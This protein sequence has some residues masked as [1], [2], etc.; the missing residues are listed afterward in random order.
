MASPAR[1]RRPHAAADRDLDHRAQGS[2]VNGGAGDGRRARWLGLCA[3]QRQRRDTNGSTPDRRAGRRPAEVRPPPASWQFTTDL[4]SVANGA[5]RTLARGFRRRLAGGDRRAGDRLADRR[6]EG[7]RSDQHKHVSSRSTISQGDQ[8]WTQQHDGVTPNQANGVAFAADGS[9]YVTGQS[10]KPPPRRRAR[11]AQL[12]QF[13]A[14][15]LVPPCVS[16]TEHPRSPPAGANTPSGNGV[17]VD[18]RLRR[19]GA[20]RRRGGHRV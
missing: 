6:P 14:G 4:G 1:P 7:Q 13:P 3:G 17:A 15:V 10:A 8:V 5:S 18:Q 2:G 16:V 9:V 12:E 20:E 19:R 11:K